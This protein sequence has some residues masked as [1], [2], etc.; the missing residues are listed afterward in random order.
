MT[1]VAGTQTPIGQLSPTVDP[2]PFTDPVEQLSVSQD[3]A[4]PVVP[5]IPQGKPDPSARRADLCPSRVLCEEFG[6]L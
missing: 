6:C 4:H 5:E 2:T 1:P 3:V